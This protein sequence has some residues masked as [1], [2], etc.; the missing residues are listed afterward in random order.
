[1]TMKLAKRTAPSRKRNDKGFSLI[2]LIIVITIMAILTALLAP[3]LLRYVEQARIAKDEAIID[4]VL[5]ASNLAL[6]NTGTYASGGMTYSANGTLGTLNPTLAP[7]LHRLLGGS[8][9]PSTTS[10]TSITGLPPLS[11]AFYRS[12]KV[13][14]NFVITTHDG[15]TVPNGGIMVDCVVTYNGQRPPA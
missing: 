2:E 14:F 9:T 13:T 15:R 5:R 7:E 6:L 1:M 4:E 10:N 12:A 11:S 3:Q 8:H